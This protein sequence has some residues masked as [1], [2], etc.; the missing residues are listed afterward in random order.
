MDELAEFS[1]GYWVRRR[2][3]ALDLTQA[4]LGRRAGASAAAIRKIEADERR[5]SRELAEHL[6][7]A[8]G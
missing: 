1:F 5:P 2:R 4:E 7:A 3:R 8:L 6:A